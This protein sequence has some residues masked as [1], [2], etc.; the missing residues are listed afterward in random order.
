MAGVAEREW[1]LSV[2]FVREI[3]LLAGHHSPKILSNLAQDGV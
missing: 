2:S 1:G 3:L